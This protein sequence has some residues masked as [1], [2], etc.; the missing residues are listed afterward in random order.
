MSDPS[1]IPSHVE[2]VWRF[3]RWLYGRRTSALLA[4]LGAVL[5]GSLAT[6]FRIVR[7]GEAGL[8]LRF[9]RVRPEPVPPGALYVVPLVESLEKVGVGNE[10]K[11]ELSRRDGSPLELITGDE[12]LVSV[13]AQIQYRAEDPIALRMRYLD[14]EAVLRSAA[15]SILTRRTATESVESILTDGKVRLQEDVRLDVQKECDRLGLGVRLA[16]VAIVMAGPPVGAEDAFTA[17]SSASAER[18]KRVSEADGKRSEALALARAEADRLRREAGSWQ[19]EQVETARGAVEKFR[20]LAREVAEERSAALTR[21]HLETLERVAASARLIVLPPGK[22]TQTIRTLLG[23]GAGIGGQSPPP[24]PS[25]GKTGEELS[26]EMALPP[27]LPEDILKG[28]LPKPS[29]PNP[30]RP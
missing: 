12:N 18:E 2:A 25:K 11:L 9:G 23:P 29:G 26:R 15:F 24:A 13:R 27:I 4:A 19:R 6:G 17:V 21:L 1:G 28:E 22:K 30:K 16:S 20:A 7:N 10:R 5:L 3:T 14:A 8:L